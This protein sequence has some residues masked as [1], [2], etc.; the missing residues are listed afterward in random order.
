MNSDTKWITGKPNPM[1][2]PIIAELG[3]VE[4]DGRKRLRLLQ[5][6]QDLQNERLNKIVRWHKYTPPKEE[7]QTDDEIV[8][9]LFQNLKASEVPITNR[10]LTKLA[11]V[12]GRKAG[13][14]QVFAYLQEYFK[15][16][17]NHPRLIEDLLEEGFADHFWAILNP[18]E[19]T[20]MQSDNEEDEAYE[21]KG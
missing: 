16:M 1:D 12:R 10:D 15:E 11:V 6:K 7:I 18:D 3:F 21:E 9:E 20:S 13:V 2:L 8:T 17:G 14:K 4:S 19:A 5:S